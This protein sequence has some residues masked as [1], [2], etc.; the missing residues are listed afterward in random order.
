MALPLKHFAFSMTKKKTTPF[1]VVFVDDIG[2][3]EINVSLRR[4]VASGAHPHH[5]GWVRVR[6]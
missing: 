5:I 4:A 6:F 2:L 3:D 1:G